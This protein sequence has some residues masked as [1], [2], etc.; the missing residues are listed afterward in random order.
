MGT[1]REGIK[2]GTGREGIKKGTV[3]EVRAI[4]DS[5]QLGQKLSLLNLCNLKLRKKLDYLS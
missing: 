1:V 2:K 4:V 5:L 3:R